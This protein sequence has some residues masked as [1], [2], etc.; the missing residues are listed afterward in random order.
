MYFDWLSLE[1]IRDELIL[2]NDGYDEN[3]IV[4]S[5]LA[6]EPVCLRRFW[7]GSLSIEPRAPKIL[8]I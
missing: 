6:S 7:T 3:V 8:V 2:N 5:C 4:E 1:H